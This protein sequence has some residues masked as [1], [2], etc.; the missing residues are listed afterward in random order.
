MRVAAIQLNSSA[1][2]KRNLDTAAVLVAEAADAGAQLV[3]LP[4]MFATL[5]AGDTVGRGRAEAGPEGPLRGYLAALAADAGVWLVGG[6]IPWAPD[7]DAEKVC[8]RC[9]VFAPDG[10]EVARYDKIH[11][12]D[13]GVDG[14]FR[15]SERYL[16]GVTPVTVEVAGWQVGLTVC[17]DLRFAELYRWLFERGAELFTVPSAFTRP[18]GAAHW[19]ILLRARAIENGAFVVAPAQWGEHAGGRKSWGHTMIIDPWGEILAQADEGDTVVIADLDRERLVDVRRQLPVG[20][21]QRYRL[22]DSAP[23]WEPR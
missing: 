21:Q 7:P 5:G 15:E 6:T 4:E 16:A 9:F 8:N 13:V 11:L 12:F 18:T 23:G 2:L 19:E 20:S 14:G 22:T 1:E 3:A 10:R 17:Y